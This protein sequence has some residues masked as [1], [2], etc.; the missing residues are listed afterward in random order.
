M[1]T[2]SPEG[3]AKTTKRSFGFKQ[4]VLP[5]NGERLVRIYMTSKTETKQCVTLSAQVTN[6]SDVSE[7]EV[8]IKLEDRLL[9]TRAQSFTDHKADLQE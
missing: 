1:C 8:A 4:S 5:P 9:E 2:R 6:P 3:S 7:L